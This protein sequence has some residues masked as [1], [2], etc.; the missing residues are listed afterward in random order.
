MFLRETANLPG[1]GPRID[2]LRNAIRANRVSFPVPV[3]VFPSQFRPDIQWRLV[4]LYF[5]R[6]WSSRKLAERYG[7]TSRR[8]QQS[9]QHWAGHAVERGYLQV[10]PAETA[11]PMP[12]RTW[13]TVSVPLMQESPLFSPIP[14]VTP[15]FA[16]QQPA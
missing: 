1:D 5:I 13:T 14:T 16:A 15:D 4:Q 2:D 8:I 12:M 7:V 10:I 6:G 9:L 11:L 3:P